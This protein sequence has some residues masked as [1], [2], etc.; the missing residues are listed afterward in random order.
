MHNN[1]KNEYNY[2][3]D[4]LLQLLTLQRF[5]INILY[6]HILEKDYVKFFQQITLVCGLSY[7]DIRAV[8]RLT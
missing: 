2:Y 1:T 6:E 7:N 8:S 3:F 5:K 4:W